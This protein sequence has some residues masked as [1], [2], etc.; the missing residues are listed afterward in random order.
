[1]I[2]APA[3]FRGRRA[4]EP[5]EVPHLWGFSARRVLEIMTPNDP[6]SAR[7]APRHRAATS[8][9]MAPSTHTTL[10]HEESGM[11]RRKRD[12]NPRRRSAKGALIKGVSQPLPRELLFEAT[13]R[14]KLR[15]W[16][17]PS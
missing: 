8:R 4:V 11:A 14:E 16:N 3:A 10:A 5:V 6:L 9:E 12:S 2:T 1:M 13:F 7:S 17:I 15:G